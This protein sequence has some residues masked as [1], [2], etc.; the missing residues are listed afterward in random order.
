MKNKEECYP[1]VFDACPVPP[2]VIFFLHETFLQ[3][4]FLS[5]QVPADIMANVTSQL[6]PVRPVPKK[7]SDYS[8]EERKTFPKLFE[9]P[10]NFVQT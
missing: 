7:L 1:T 8:E 9:F 6:S 4:L 2:H 5:T 3:T 10:E